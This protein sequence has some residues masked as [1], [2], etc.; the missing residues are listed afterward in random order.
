[1]GTKSFHPLVAMAR[2]RQRP[3]AGSIVRE[4][5]TPY[6]SVDFTG[7]FS[8][9]FAVVGGQATKA[10]MP[11]R[12]TLDW[13]VLV[14]RD[15]LDRARRDLESA[16]AH[17]FRSLTIPRFS[18]RLAGGEPVDVVSGEAGW[19]AGALG[20]PNRAE[21]GGQPV[22]G[23]PYL[24]LM[25][26]ESGRVQDLADVSRMLGCAADETFD[27][28][29]SVVV[30]WLPDALDDLESLWELGKMERDGRKG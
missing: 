3:G 13:D 14:H 27:V 20:R 11:A 7:M 19:V 17:S 28:V 9:P 23:L 6:F 25:K 2:R 18:C 15:D 16:G 26:M 4:P 30:R 10:Y 12:H 24:V 1:M 5:E 22:L 29:R 8:V 21:A